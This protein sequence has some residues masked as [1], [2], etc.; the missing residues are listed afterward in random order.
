MASN[1]LQAKWFI[2]VMILAGAQVEGASPNFPRYFLSRWPLRSVLYIRVS[3]CTYKYTQAPARRK[4]I[5]IIDPQIQNYWCNRICGYERC[6]HS[7]PKFP[8]MRNSRLDSLESYKLDIFLVRCTH[9]MVLRRITRFPLT[10]LVPKTSKLWLL[11]LCCTYLPSVG[12]SA[13]SSSHTAKNGS[14]SY[15]IVCRY[16]LSGVPIRFDRPNILPRVPL[17]CHGVIHK[18]QNMR[19]SLECLTDHAPKV[20]SSCSWRHSTRYTAPRCYVRNVASSICC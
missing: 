1:T 4:I 18:C 7:I 14:S 11:H 12:T 2:L 5:R 16:L 19:C 10:K 15:G 9:L 20:L 17:Q 8:W 13:P 3:E 6:T